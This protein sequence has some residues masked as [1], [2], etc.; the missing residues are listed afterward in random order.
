MPAG[1]FGS[2]L[3][4]KTMGLANNVYAQVGLIMLVGLLG[5]NAVLDRGVR[6]AEARGGHDRARGGY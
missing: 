1:I 3:L 6:G 2:F 5:K 4:I